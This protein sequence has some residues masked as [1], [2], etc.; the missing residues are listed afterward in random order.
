MAMTMTAYSLVDAAVACVPA[1][2]C[3]IYSWRP[4][5]S[6]R[7]TP[8]FVISYQL[9]CPNQFCSSAQDPACPVPIFSLGRQRMIIFIGADTKHRN[10]IL[11]SNNNSLT[12]IEKV[13]F[14]TC[15]HENIFWICKGIHYVGNKAIHKQKVNYKEFHIH[16]RGYQ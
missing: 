8:R 16:S 2:A 13:L 11:V 14:R 1:F 10:G 4:K 15:K 9:M 5:F 6:C 7:A 12:D 3:N